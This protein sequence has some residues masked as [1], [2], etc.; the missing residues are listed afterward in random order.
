MNALPQNFQAFAID[1]GGDGV[2]VGVRG[3]RP[4]WSTACQRSGKG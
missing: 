1:L 2:N 4:W 3:D